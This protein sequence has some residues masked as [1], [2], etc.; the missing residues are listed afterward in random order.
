[1]TQHP[2]FT[3]AS[4][5]EKL[6]VLRNDRPRGS[7]YH[8]FTHAEDDDAHGRYAKQTPSSVAGSEPMVR[9]PGSVPAWVTDTGPP[10]L[11]LGYS[12]EAQEPTGETFEIEASLGNLSQAAIAPAQEGEASLPRPPSTNSSSAEISLAAETGGGASIQPPSRARRP[13]R[14]HQAEYAVPS[15]S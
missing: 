2:F 4:D 11:S 8:S 13:Q 5:Q 9:Y 15:P 10:E 12:I 1:M 14:S 7:T 3:E 6:D